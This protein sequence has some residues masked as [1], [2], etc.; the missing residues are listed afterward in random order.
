MCHALHDLLG[1]CQLSFLACA[2]EC[3]CVLCEGCS[4]LS[5]PMLTLCSVGRYTSLCALRGMLCPESS[6]A[7]LVQYGLFHTFLCSAKDAL[8]HVTSMMESM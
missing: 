2:T 4:A 1:M 7:Q 8:P 3:L 6:Y 5:H